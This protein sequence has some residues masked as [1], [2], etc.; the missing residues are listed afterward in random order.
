MRQIG[1]GD[2]PVKRGKGSWRIGVSYVDDLGNPQ[3]ERRTV[4]C[5][6]ITEAR[7]RTEE[8]RLELL[9]AERIVD[10]GSVTLEQF[11]EGH[12]RYL[13]DV[14]HRSPSTL[15]GYRDIVRTRWAP[16]MGSVRLAE[17]SP[18]SIEKQLG[19]M[20]TKG[21]EHGE[22]LSGSTC[23]KAFSFLK[24]ALK[25]AVRL[26]YIPANPC[27]MVDSP[28][29]DK[30][31]VAVI[32]ESEVKRMKLLLKGHP[33]YRFATAVN[34]ALDTGMRRGELCGL[35]WSDVDIEN[36][37]IHVR[38]AL[39]EAS[40]EDTYNGTTLQDKDPKSDTSDRWV[41]LPGPTV[42]LLRRHAETQCY[43]LAYF[44]IEQT[45]DTPVLCGNLGEDY[46]P[47]KFTSDFT[48]FANQHGFNIT[49]H[50]LRHTHASLLLKGGVPIQYVSQRLGHENVAVTYR[51]YA[52]FLP[53][54]DG[55]SA[56][57]WEKV[58]SDDEPTYEPPSV[59]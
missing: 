1:K 31:K 14:K 19:W 47:S 50:G 3:R 5:K 27:D 15:R 46:R 26:G 24:T 12:I 40:P 52:H 45:Q 6:T 22:P 42:D 10:K 4:H 41:S 21:G 25:R 30:A 57:A 9:Q 17:V 38:R 20:R 37:R 33:D 18:A 54:D 13:H 53:G 58:V 43:R 51:F 55:G 29:R 48:A 2:K 28:S 35:L 59:A 8:L 7:M 56:E 16:T 32:D 49:L 23:Q 34:L 11:L 36:S 39:A 44:G